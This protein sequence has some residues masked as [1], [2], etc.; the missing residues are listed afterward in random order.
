MTSGAAAGFAVAAPPDTLFHLGRAPDPVNWWPATPLDLDDPRGGGRF[1]APNGDYSTLYC[2]SERYGCLLEKFADLRVTSASRE[3]DVR[4]DAT[5]VH[6]GDGDYRPLVTGSFP[7]DGLDG[8]LMGKLQIDPDAQFVDVGDPRTHTALQQLI[9]TA[10]LKALGLHR[11]DIGAFTHPD[12]RVTRQVAEEL[13]VL[14]AD[15]FAGIRYPSVLDPTA[16]C[17]AMWEDARGQL[18][19]PVD[20]E[21]IDITSPDLARA[22]PA[23]GL[24][25]PPH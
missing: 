2:G 6:D 25:L 17:W 22:L 19:H 14:L 13:H 4:I 1:D 12:R 5:V 3:L 10:L 23:L 11:I 9:G 21:P 15:T 8:W 7:A 20:V 18:L 16:E 24:V